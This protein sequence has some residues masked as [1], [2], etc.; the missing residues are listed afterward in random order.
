MKGN[1][2]PILE[3]EAKAMSLE[4]VEKTRGARITKVLRG[5]IW[6]WF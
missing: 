1:R 2:N 3:I 5:E 4:D 6:F